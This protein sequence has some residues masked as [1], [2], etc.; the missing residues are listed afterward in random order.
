M[1]VLSYTPMRSSTS[2]FWTPVCSN[3]WLLD[4]P[5]LDL[6]RKEDL[7]YAASLECG[8]IGIFFSNLISLL[9]KRLNLRQRVTATACVFF[10]RFF[11]KNS[12]SA[13][14]PFLVA[15]TC[16]YVSA[17]VEESPVHIKSVVAEATRTSQE[18]GCRTFPP[19]NSSVAEMEF[20]LLEE[21]EFDLV[22]HHPYRSLIALYDSVGCPRNHVHDG[23]GFQL[24]GAGN[25]GVDTGSQAIGDPIS[26]GVGLSVSQAEEIAQFGISGLHSSEERDS[27]LQ[28]GQIRLHE[29]DEHIL[30]MTWFVLN[31]TYKTDLPLMHPPY[32]LALASLWLALVLHTSSHDKIG[33]SVRD[34]RSRREQ[35]DMQIEQILNGSSSASSSDRSMGPS[36]M[37]RPPEPPSED[38]LTFFAHLNVSIQLLAEIVQD[39]L[40]SYQLQNVANALVKDGPRV[41]KLLDHMRDRRR[42]DLLQMST[43][44]LVIHC[45][46]NETVNEDTT[47]GDCGPHR[48]GARQR[49]CQF[50]IAGNWDMSG[51]FDAFWEL[52]DDFD[53]IEPWQAFFCERVR[54]EDSRVSTSNRVTLRQSARWSVNDVWHVEPTDSLP[55]G[56]PTIFRAQHGDHPV[57]VGVWTPFGVKAVGCLYEL[58]AQTSSQLFLA[59]RH[60]RAAPYQ[61]SLAAWLKVLLRRGVAAEYATEAGCA[62]EAT[63]RDGMRGV[64]VTH[65]FTINLDRLCR[66]S[67]S[68]WNVTQTLRSRQ[69]PI[70]KMDGWDNP[71]STSA[72]GWDQKSQPQQPQQHQQYT[73]NSTYANNR[74]QYA[75]QQAQEYQGYPPNNGWSQSP[76]RGGRGGRRG[77]GGGYYGGAGG[78]GG[79]GADYHHQ[80][81]KEQREENRLRHLRSQLFKL[82]GEKDF[83]P[84][85][86]LLKMSRWI[87]DKARDGVD[88]ITASFRVMVTE[89]PHKI[90]LIAALIGFLCLS[91]QAEAAR[92][93]VSKAPQAERPEGNDDMDQGG[94][95][96]ASTEK[97]QHQQQEQDSLGIAIVKDLVKAFRSYLDARLWRNTRLTLHLFAALVPL[98]IIPAASLRAL[99][100]SF[101]AVLDEPGVSA[102]RGDRA[103]LCIIETLCRAGQDLLMDS[104]QAQADLDGLV[105]KVVNYNSSRKVELEL[106]RPVH[107]TEGIWLD[108]FENAV[109]ALEALRVSGYRRPAFLAIPEDLLPAAISPSVTSVPKDLRVVTLPDV[110][111]PPDDDV[112]G[113]GLDVAYAQLGVHQV[114]KRRID[115]GKGEL[116]EK[117]AAVGPERVG[118]QPRWFANTTPK[119]GTPSS[120]VLRAVLADMMDLYEV[121]R[122]DAS[123]LLLDL[124]KWMRRG[125]FAGKASS[126]A[127]LFGEIDEEW[128]FVGPEASVEGAWSLDDLLVE[129]ILSTALVLPSSPRNPLYYT[130]LLR[131]IVCLT[132]GTVAPS[133]GRTI[134]AWYNAMATGK[135][136]VEAINRF[137]DWFAI[138]LSNFNFGWAWKEWIPDTAL[139]AEH[140]KRAFMR[141]VVEL[142]IRLAYYDRIKQTLPDEIQAASLPTEEPTPTFTYADEAHAYHGQAA[143]LI[144]SIRAKA[145]AEVLL[146]E[147]ESFKA[148]IFDASGTALPSSGGEGSVASALEADLV[149][150]DLT[151]QCILQVGSRSF[152]HFLNIVERYHSL[153]RQLSRSSRMRL[154]I[155]AGSVRF[156]ARSAQWIQIV[157][158]KLLQ[159]RIVE[160]AD[161]VE[162]VF[163]PPTDEP[164]SILVGSG[165]QIQGGHAEPTRDWSTFNWWCILRLTLDKV[166]GRVD[167]LKKRLVEI[168]RSEAEEQERKEAAA[169]AGLQDGEDPSNPRSGEDL[170]M[171]GSN[172]PLFPTSALL[173]PKQLT[174][175]EK[176]QQTQI[177]SQEALNSLDSIKAE[178]RKVLITSI[179]GFKSLLDSQP[180]S[181]EEK[182]QV[183]STSQSWQ[184]WWVNSYATEFARSYNRQLLENRHLVLSNCFS[185]LHSLRE[186]IERAIDMLSE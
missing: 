147:F 75:S 108:G 180:A 119:V 96:S 117:K 138:H 184:R 139:P 31:D 151:I 125:T 140:P 104:E 89:Q 127:G 97:Q 115:T 62:D 79:G 95:K 90:P 63:M 99:L 166:N 88:P 30:Q 154:A 23:S 132:P 186:T 37:P 183:P 29:L 5:Q 124:P 161:V 93:T 61:T 39:L 156:W 59:G 129:T 112:E 174:E 52:A 157:L 55:L 14:D 53:G 48:Q 32:M 141:R 17:K 60:G 168:Q 80:Q 43:Q 116:E 118:Q 103:S 49:T 2:T 68:N 136:D 148:T 44:R 36:S 107:D 71:S 86:D 167:Q 111:V 84:P 4:R 137:A 9:C 122:K 114:K 182:D 69:T 12:Y 77:G 121:N 150:R 22:V 109:Q 26:L 158:D 28:H 102:V 70:R 185:S 42:Q 181:S 20:Y 126:E 146:A 165:A 25:S 169:V 67:L 3:H 162:F 35:H 172:L 1:S 152:S 105:D 98:Q 10:R 21:M 163:A 123:R 34:M 74:N 133:L 170:Q 27:G 171:P 160:P 110:L 135:V 149:V 113:E 45:D 81:S 54:K 179:M 106:A 18:V 73:S 40:S 83:H 7:Q 41:V 155:L 131:E 6:A 24:G 159:Y 143:R 33:A 78:G 92:G 164:G 50:H 58:T 8:A 94:E 120:V 19:D 176:R 91:S 142:E 134:R 100:S 82:G 16:V 13:S 144:N 11:A 47:M 145:S 130:S 46:E 38:A 15:A 64:H 56:D 51:V 173:P 101:G 65:V 72:S 85:S 178:Q 175:E 128:W 76:R 87:E 57:K 177:S 66:V 153:L